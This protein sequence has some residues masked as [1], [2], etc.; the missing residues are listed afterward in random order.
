MKI[1]ESWGIGI[2]RTYHSCREYGIKEPELSE[3]GDSFRMNLY[4]LSYEK[5][6]KSSSK[7]LNS[8]KNRILEIL[9]VNGSPVVSMELKC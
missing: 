3:I 2:K 8:T 4:R 9:F 1:I 5:N 6:N 7:S